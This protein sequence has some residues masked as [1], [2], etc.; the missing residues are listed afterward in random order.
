MGYH[1]YADDQQ[2]CVSYQPDVPADL[3]Q[4]L[5]RLQNYIRDIKAWIVSVKLRLFDKND[6]VSG[7]DGSPPVQNE[8][9]LAPVSS[10]GTLL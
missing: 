1:S 4:A 8:Q 6:R 5:S 9:L 3:K 2:L 7:V 10:W